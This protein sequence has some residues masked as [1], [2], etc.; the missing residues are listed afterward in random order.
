MMATTLT[1]LWAAIALDTVCEALYEEMAVCP[2]E[3]APHGNALCPRC[4]CLA[5]L[6]AAASDLSQRARELLVRQHQEEGR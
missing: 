3:A 6:L 5:R 1:D 2:C 4:D